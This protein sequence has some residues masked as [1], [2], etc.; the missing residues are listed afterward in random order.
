MTTNDERRRAA[1]AFRARLEDAFRNAGV[2]TT[3]QIWTCPAT[4]GGAIEVN[5]VTTQSVKAREIFVLVLSEF[6]SEPQFIPI[7]ETPEEA[8]ITMPP[9]SRP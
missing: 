5:V 6:P 2:Q 8:I 1:E 9:S 3:G 7:I 4:S